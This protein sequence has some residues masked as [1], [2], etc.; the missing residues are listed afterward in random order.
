MQQCISLPIKKNT[1]GNPLWLSP[2]LVSSRIS[3]YPIEA[4]SKIRI[5]EGW[6]AGAWRGRAPLP[7]ARGRRRGR[8]SVIARAAHWVIARNRRPVGRWLGACTW[9]WPDAV[10]ERAATARCGGRVQA[11]AVLCASSER[12][13]G[14]PAW[15]SSASSSSPVRIERARRRPSMSS[16]RARVAMASRRVATADRLGSNEASA[17]RRQR[18][19][20]GG[21]PERWG[22]LS[23][24]CLA[25]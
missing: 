21:G 2:P 24:R 9:R 12:S 15:R 1:R 25:V 19:G 20:V 14:S 11:A 10:G 23:D 4:A 7:V 17:Q 18:V 6:S 13:G 16:V 5:Q 8:H 3:P 22:T